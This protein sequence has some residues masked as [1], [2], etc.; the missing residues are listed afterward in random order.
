MCT[1]AATPS[2]AS[3]KYEIFNFPF[4]FLNKSMSY[5]G[6]LIFH[7]CDELIYFARFGFKCWKANVWLS[8]GKYTVVINPRNIW[9]LVDRANDTGTGCTIFW[10]YI[11]INSFNLK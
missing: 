3:L 6:K 9:N 4:Q 8:K 7:S 11:F 5:Y 2:A 10:N 1:E